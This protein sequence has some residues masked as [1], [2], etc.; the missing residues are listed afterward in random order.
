M[1]TDVPYTL[2]SLRISRDTW[3]SGGSPLRCSVEFAGLA[4][5]VEID[6]GE[7]TT[8]AVLAVVADQI[9][10][11]ATMRAADMKAAF[12]EGAAQALAIAK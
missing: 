8:A 3:R 10:A 12:V 4:G 6:L 1:M 2:N 5:K 7:E 11:A 9:V